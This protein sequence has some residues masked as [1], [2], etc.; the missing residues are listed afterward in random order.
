M[1]PELLHRKGVL[2]E[3]SK[4]IELLSIPQNDHQGPLNSTANS[5]AAA[6]E[7]SGSGIWGD[8]NINKA[9]SGMKISGDTGLQSGGFSGRPD[10]GSDNA[11]TRASVDLGTLG[12]RPNMIPLTSSN[13]LTLIGGSSDMQTLNNK[14]TVNKNTPIYTHYI[15][16]FWTPIAKNQAFF[17]TFISN[18]HQLKLVKP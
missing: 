13:S 16:G 11:L 17:G 2:F 8:L 18:C 4:Q 15:A 7:R 3:N 9:L 10:S 6:V 14:H 5:Q 1:L 12:H